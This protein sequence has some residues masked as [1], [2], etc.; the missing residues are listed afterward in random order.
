MKEN[1]LKIVSQDM[2]QVV[3]NAKAKGKMMNVC[4][5]MKDII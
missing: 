5:V 2:A 3:K 1:V 4:L